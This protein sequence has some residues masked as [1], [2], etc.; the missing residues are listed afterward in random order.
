MR[1]E[2]FGKVHRVGGTCM[3]ANGTLVGEERSGI[4]DGETASWERPRSE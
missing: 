1:A 2:L 3:G 4:T